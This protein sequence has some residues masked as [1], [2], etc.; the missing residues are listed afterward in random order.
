MKP[1]SYLLAW[2]QIAAQ[3]YGGALELFV[4]DGASED[5]TRALVETFSQIIPGMILLDNPQRA[6]TTS[7]N[8]AIRRTSGQI[9]I[10]LDAHATYAPDYVRQC[11]AAFQRTTAA[12][13]GGGV[14]LLPESGYL[15]TLFGLVQEHPFGTGVAYFPPD[16][17]RGSGRYSLAGS[18]QTAGV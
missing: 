5:G 18:L 15:P 10:R 7:L 8:L 13:V 14:N 3:D 11:I 1:P 4:V 9:I 2:S 12:C 6:Q 16:C 17:L